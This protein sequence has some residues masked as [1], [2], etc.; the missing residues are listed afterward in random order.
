VLKRLA[1]RQ[2]LKLAE[3]ANFVEKPFNGD[4]LYPFTESWSPS[5]SKTA[6][7]RARPDTDDEEPKGTRAHKN[8][9]NSKF[10]SQSLYR[11]NIFSASDL[12][13]IL[14]STMQ[15]GAWKKS[16]KQLTSLALSTNTWHKY[17]AAFQKFQK[18]LSDTEQSLSW[19]LQPV[20][21]NG[22]VVWCKERDSL[23]PQSVKSYIFGL[24]KIQK[25]L[26]FKGI[27]LAKSTTDDLLKGWSHGIKNVIHKKGKMNLNILKKI[28]KLAKNQFDKKTFLTIWAACSLAFFTSCRMG[29]IL[30]NLSSDNDDRGPLTWGD[31]QCSRISLRIQLRK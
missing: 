20:V 25:F 2:E 17:S 12:S 1:A 21:L 19:P 7:K 27:E 4:T 22:F 14:P 11:N 18:Y 3:A 9:T 13:N 23:S 24:S 26:G 16:V 10:T 6:R 15:N 28:R 8:I 5:A 31:E 30:A 29:E